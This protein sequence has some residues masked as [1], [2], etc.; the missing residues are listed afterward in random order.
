MTSF[1]RAKKIALSLPD[2]EEGTA[3]GTRALL[4]RGEMFAVRAIHRSA[5]PSSLSVLVGFDARDRL[6]AADPDIYYLPKHYVNY[7]VV[8][9]R[10]RRIRPEALR[11][12]F[13]LAHR[14]VSTRAKGR[15]D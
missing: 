13:Q 15:R 1:D 7:P 14:F 2:V 3:Y 11:K 8:L 9:V 4:V 10:L 6:L 5:E 12:L